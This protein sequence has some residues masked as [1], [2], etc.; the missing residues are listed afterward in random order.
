MTLGEVDDVVAEFNLD[1]KKQAVLSGKSGFESIKRV[2]A[3]TNVRIF[4]PE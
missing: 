1:R 4:I 2:S 3:A